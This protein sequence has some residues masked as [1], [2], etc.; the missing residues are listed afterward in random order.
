MNRTHNQSEATDM[1]LKES[2]AIH[3]SEATDG[4]QPEATGKDSTVGCDQKI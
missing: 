3:Q 4:M 1:A 2:L